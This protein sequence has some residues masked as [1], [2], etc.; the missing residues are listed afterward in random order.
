LPPSIR[1]A[2]TLPQA[3]TEWPRSG[4]STAP[5][6]CF[7]SD[8]ADNVTLRWVALGKIQWR[9][10]VRA[11]GGGIV[12]RLTGT[13]RL[14]SRE[15]S[16]FAATGP[17]LAGPSIWHNAALLDLGTIE[18]RKPGVAR[19]SRAHHQTLRMALITRARIVSRAWMLIP[20]AAQSWAPVTGGP[21]RRTLLAG[22]G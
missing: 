13:D 17:P 6:L 14:E 1:A 8:S 5:M 18:I 4:S 11:S 12:T 22:G 20:C 10:S 9:A 16:V 7:N 19:T 15:L 21:G 2:T 3:A